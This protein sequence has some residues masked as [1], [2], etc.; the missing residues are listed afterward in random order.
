M[1][2]KNTILTVAM[3]GAICL[4]GSVMLLA[5]AP[6]ASS[7]SG[8][9]SSS[10][11]GQ[12][13]LVGTV[14]AA[15][16]ISMAADPT[17]AKLHPS[18]VTAQEIVTD[19][20]GDLQNVIVFVSEGLQ[21]QT[22]EP[23]Q[24]PAVIEQ[25]GCMFAPHVVAMRANQPLEMVNSDP[26][27]HNIHPMPANN[28][29]WNKA[30]PPGTKVDETFPREEVAIPVK[31]N[32]HPWMKSYVAVFKHPFYAVTGKDGSFDLEHLPPGTYTIEAWHEKLGKSTQQVTIGTNETKTVEFVFKSGSGS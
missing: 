13:K 22:F 16:T 15:K 29:E 2:S 1:K 4:T 19:G 28:R 6:S 14:P 11:K 3:A 27:S 18:P 26:T 25:K 30:E 12:V 7:S 24:Q 21:G 31:C 5:G 8:G 23:P 20:K 10:L 9:A 17:C 32:V